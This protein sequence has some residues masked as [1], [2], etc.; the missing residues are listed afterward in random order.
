MIAPTALLLGLG[1]PALLAAAIVAGGQR[2]AIARSGWLAGLALALGYGAGHAGFLGWPAFPAR[3]AEQ[4]IPY[5]A[6]GAA[7][8]ATLATASARSPRWLD[9]VLRAV[10]LGVA[11]ALWLRPM[12][13]YQWTAAASAGWL[14]GLLV[15]A[16]LACLGLDRVLES[17]EPCAAWTAVVCTFGGITV[18]LALSGS[19]ALGQIAGSAAAAATGGLG[20]TL[21]PGRR[22][23]GRESVLVLVTIAAGLLLCGLFYAD[24]PRASALLLAVAPLAAGAIPRAIRERSTLG[25][26]LA[27]VAVV[28]LVVGAAAGIAFAS[29]PPFDSA[30]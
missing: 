29:S 17:L 19:L 2:V 5:A 30:Y 22:P 12:M 23:F 4:W 27:V 26:A 25:G 21:L 6:C 18:T 16:L 11:L 28:G 8:L 13:A 1:I 7:V 20:A 15:L 10:L 24:L 3:V 14:A 9:W